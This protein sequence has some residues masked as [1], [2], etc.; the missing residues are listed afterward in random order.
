LRDL[1]I[2]VPEAVR[3]GSSVELSCDYDL[4]GALLYSIK[5]YKDDQEFYSYVPKEAPPTRVF[6]VPG[7]VVDVSPLFDF[8]SKLELLN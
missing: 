5:W 6:P 7:V 1:Q 2:K 8:S 3:R 4:E